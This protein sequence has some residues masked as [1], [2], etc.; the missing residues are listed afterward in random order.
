M[1]K[2]TELTMKYSYNDIMVVPAILSS[3]Q[4]RAECNPY[5]KNGML[6][7]FTAPM[8]SV[9]GKENFDLFEKHGII[10]ILP[11]TE[12]LEDRL[13]Y[14]FKGKWAAFSLQEFEKWFTDETASKTDIKKIRA[15]IDIAN[16]HVER[17]YSLVR[18]SKA[19]F[20]INIEIMV[21]NIANPETYR[22][23]V[24]SQ[25][26]YVRCSVGTGAGC[27]TCSNTAIGYPI[28][29]LISEIVEIKE[30][31]IKRGLHNKNDLPKIIADGGIRNYN[32]IIKAIALGADYVMCGSIFSRMMESASVKVMDRGFSE[33][34]KKIRL[35]FPIE[36]YENLRYED[37]G[38]IGDYTDEFVKQMSESGHTAE[39]EN[40]AIGPIYAKFYGMASRA[41]QIAM[42]GKK[43]H[44]SEGIEKMLEVTYTIKTWVENM[45]DYLQS[46][47]SY[48]N[49]RTIDELKQA[50]VVIVS[51]NT[52][53]SINK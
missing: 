41:G 16:G 10:P 19:I 35:R 23:C 43:V 52:Y 33:G 1:G 40:H 39:K 34:G 29:S 53:N 7:L 12:E 20:G 51:M 6:P 11:R 47:M 14:A 30:E 18:K 3:I 48:T 38:W 25:V 28:A 37:G 44:T 5:Y 17:L 22:V 2:L 13:D 31:Y 8:D 42:K 15:L 27:I 50:S 21:G 24:E 4:H 32:D 49:S 9:V 36:H 26:D 46:A 45:T